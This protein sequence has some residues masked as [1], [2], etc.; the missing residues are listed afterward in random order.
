MIWDTFMAAGELDMLECRLVELQDVPDLMHVIVEADTD[1]Q[2]HPKPYHITENLDRFAAWSER[3]RIVRATDLPDSPDAW[4]R[5]HAQRE[6]TSQGLTDADPDDVVLHG[7]LDE[8]P[9]VTFTRHVKPRG[10][11]VAG[12]TFHPFAV[13]W[14]HPAMW[15]GTV[16]AR[17]RDIGTFTAMRDARLRAS[18]IPRSGWHFSWVGGHQ[19]TLDK[20]NTFCHPEVM[21]WAAEPLAANDFY[22]HGYH[23]DGARLDAVE[24]DRWWPRWIQDRKCPDDWFRPRDVER[25]TLNVG[26][27]QILKP[28]HM[29]A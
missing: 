2:G 24:V 7:D 28:K 1:H 15:P 14:Q 12:Q 20:T 3:I 27:G 29:T 4:D 17:T 23:V 8:I 11:V 5:E 16:A 26:A 19:Y 25:R 22:R 21:Q 18:V 13:D 10:F 6:W 9:T